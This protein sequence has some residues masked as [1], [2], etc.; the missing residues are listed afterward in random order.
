MSFKSFAFL[1]LTFLFIAF[2][3][4]TSEED[5]T[6]NPNNPQMM[7]ND[8]GGELDD[9][10]S[11]SL[12]TTS[13]AA[14]ESSQFEGK[15]LVIFFF[16]YN[17][18]PCRSVG[19]DVEDRLHQAFKDEDK[20]AI[21]GAD[22][23]EGNDAGVN[24]FA[25]VTGITFPLGRKGAEMARDFGTTYDRLVIVNTE[26]KIVFRGSSIVANHLNEAIDVVKDL[27]Q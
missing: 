7:D 5:P 4:C 17:C 14:I 24:D 23:W 9:A 26:G 1:C 10:P 11:F 3:S 18:P 21:I 22:Q 27:L 25:D 13:G 8:P 15:N 2:S 20:F 6:L 12:E 19:P 16:G